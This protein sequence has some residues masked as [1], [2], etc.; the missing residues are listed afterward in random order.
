MRQWVI[1]CLCCLQNGPLHGQLTED[2]SDG[3]L[4]MNP[5]WY[6]DHNAFRV[7]EDKML[8]LDADSMGT[9]FL[10][11]LSHTFQQAS[12]EIRLIM[13]FNPSANNFCQIFL[14]SDRSDLTA[15]LNGYFLKVGDSEDDISLYRQ[16]DGNVTK[17][18]DGPDDFLDQSRV[19][20]I[21]LTERDSLGRWTLE[22][23]HFTESSFVTFGNVIDTTHLSP[24]FYGVMC[25]YTA[26]RSDK[27]F[28]DDIRLAGPLHQDATPPQLQ[29]LKP[30][31]AH[32]IELIFSEPL[33]AGINLH[34]FFLDGIGNP[35]K[36]TFLGPEAMV[37]E[38]EKPFIAGAVHQL[39]GQ[40]LP[41]LAGNLFSFEREFAYALP[42]QA[43]S[44]DIIITEIMADPSP[45]VEQPPKEY[46][47]LYNPGNNVLDLQQLK[48]SDNTRT[49]LLPHYLLF[50]KEYVILCPSALSYLFSSQSRVLGVSPWPSLNNTG[51]RI[52]LSSNDD[53]TIHFV[54]YNDSWYRS[55]L[56]K[57]GGW[58][59][60]MIDPGYPC[61]GQD[62]W[63]ASNDPSGGTP[64]RTN[65]VST[66]NPDLSPPL[67][68]SS[69]ARSPDTVQL[70]FDQ[71]LQAQSISNVKMEFTPVLNIDTVI[72]PDNTKPLIQIILEEN[73]KPGQIYELEISNLADCNGN[74]QL[75]PQEKVPVGWPMPA[76]SGDLVISE[77]LFNPRPLGV[78]FV[79]I[80]NRSTKAIDLKNWQFG[81]WQGSSVVNLTLLARDHLMLYP[82]DL[83]VFT[84][85]PT[86][87]KNQYPLCATTTMD[88][89]TALPS[90]PDLSGS[91][92]L[93]NRN[94][95]LIDHFSYQQDMHHPLLADK[96]GV[97]L[98]RVSYQIASN[99]SGN[100]VSASE[101]VG[102]ATPGKSNSQEY[103]PPGPQGISI[104]PKL[105][106][107]LSM[108][109]PQ[110][111]HIAFTLD[112][113]GNVAQVTVFN[114]EGKHV[115][116]LATNTLVGTMGSFIWDGTDKYGR[117]VP[118]GQY[119]ILVRITDAQGT[120]RRWKDT[121]VVAPEY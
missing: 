1:I 116:N 76:D 14:A 37:L 3:E 44:F 72:L 13:E 113:P 33:A 49:A 112:R 94:G 67:V 50:P 45:Y 104:F 19:D 110:Y 80:Y 30:Q 109:L 5:P 12:W 103:P 79:E 54:E 121:V 101:H 8:Q 85:D 66:S 99:A 61:S 15:D 71:Q 42:N 47:E 119:L 105:I 24:N 40:N 86:S 97:S 27:F 70:E 55:E 59:L 16:S 118:M 51:D 7:T 93:L 46:L 31:D 62:N 17:I 111:A 10:S 6:G 22:A 63:T 100:W 57:H 107:P 41:D 120:S 34:Q 53:H 92:L 25:T 52:I 95:V 58:S 98:E 9:S 21:I 84:T 23:K 115:N 114:A 102:Y 11:T 91:I 60:E 48:L 74:F 38:F 26:T 81:R 108:H 35:G 28:F 2:F 106:S 18:I 64:G 32:S 4:L 96:N 69:F 77:V 65:S 90:M 73:L 88:Q 75:A 39:S 82:G 117:R 89:V 68:I 20:L 36:I 43:R 83:R 78:R 56:K 87:L 29:S